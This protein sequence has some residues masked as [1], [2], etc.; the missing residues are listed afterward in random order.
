MERLCKRLMENVVSKHAEREHQRRRGR[1]QVCLFNLNIWANWHMEANTVNRVE[2]VQGKEEGYSRDTSCLRWVIVCCILLYES[3][4]GVGKN[5][6]ISNP[7]TCRINQVLL[8]LGCVLHINILVPAIM[9]LFHR[10]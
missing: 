10:Q 3:I 8:S 6:S 1:Q 2:E 4:D 9:T 7:Y 5:G